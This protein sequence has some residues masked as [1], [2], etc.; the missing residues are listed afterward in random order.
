MRGRKPKPTKI[1]ELE[2][3]PGRRPLNDRE[4][5]PE[6]AD[7]RVPRGRL[8]AEG[9]RLWKILAE[10]LAR[11]GILT[12]LDLPALEMLCHHFSIARSGKLESDRT[13]VTSTGA[14]GKVKNPATSV[15]EQNSKLFI[16]YAAEFGLTP[17]S[18][19]RIKVDLKEKEKTLAELLFE[20]IESD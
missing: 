19:V 9:R 10:P 6:L 12:E 16:R 14:R 17:S 15:F 2:G 11:N 4:P 1:K 3:N 18:R 7:S 13:G 20:G 5:K 8:D